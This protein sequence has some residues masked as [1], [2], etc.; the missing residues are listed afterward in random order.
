M[1]GDVAFALGL[2]AFVGVAMSVRVIK[3]FERVVLFELGRVKDGARGPGVIFI[4]PFVDRV[5]RV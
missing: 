3:Q 4:V 2:V 5:H 1:I